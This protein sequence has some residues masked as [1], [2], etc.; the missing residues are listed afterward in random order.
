MFMLENMLLALFG[1]R[2][3][4]WMDRIGVAMDV[5]FVA[6]ALGM[7]AFLGVWVRS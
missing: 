6:V 1:E 5:V 2:A 4:K 7:F 3:F